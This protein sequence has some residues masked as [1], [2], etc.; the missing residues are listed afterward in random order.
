VGL[1]KGEFTERKLHYLRNFSSIFQYRTKN[2]VKVKLKSSFPS[3]ERNFGTPFYSR[4]FTLNLNGNVYYV[5]ICNG[6]YSTKDA[7]ESIEVYSIEGDTLNSSVKLIKTKR[8]LTNTIR[9][10]YDFFSIVDWQNR[11]L[12]KVDKSDSS[13]TIPVVYKNGKVTNKVIKYKF[14]GQYFEVEKIEL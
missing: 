2:G 13:F 9:V 14:N 3:D 8:G 10:D 12:I 11:T 4:L 7:S 6:I 1:G 5:A